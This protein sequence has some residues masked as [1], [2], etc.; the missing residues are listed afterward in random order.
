MLKISKEKL[1]GLYSKISASM[2]LYM[3]LKKAGE[4]NYGLW[5]DGQESALGILKTVKSPK[6]FFF[7]QSETMMKFKTEGKSIEILDVREEQ[8]PF[9]L[10]GV[11]ACDFKAFD[12]LDRVFLAEP[13]DT[14]YQSRRNAGIIVTLAC[15]RPEESCFA[16]CSAS[17]RRSLPATLRRGWMRNISIGARIPRGEMP[18]RKA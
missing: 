4:A 14:Y 16:K 15:S 9:V 8:K 6:D 10:F 17:T 18:L 11:K 2:P 1:N 13:V 7:P 3:P 12:V 5:S